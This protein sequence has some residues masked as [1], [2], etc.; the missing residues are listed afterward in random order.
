MRKIS[1][2]HWCQL[3]GRQENP[4]FSGRT[5]L[6]IPDI[7]RHSTPCAALSRKACG[8]CK[9]LISKCL[10]QMHRFC[11]NNKRFCV[12]LF[13]DKHCWM[14]K[15]ARNLEELCDCANFISETNTQGKHVE[16]RQLLGK[17]CEQVIAPEQQA[18]F[19]PLVINLNCSCNISVSKNIRF[20]NGFDCRLPFLRWIIVIRQALIFSLF[21]KT[22]K[23]N[24]PRTVF[25]NLHWNQQALK[26]LEFHTNERLATTPVFVKEF[27]MLLRYF[28]SH[29]I[30]KH[31]LKSH[32]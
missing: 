31:K 1:Q 15:V 3:A 12:P 18:Q 28:H 23:N 9:F 4:L 21:T 6:S 30:S 2:N 20:P 17:M 14:I 7:P 5:N 8:V 22:K 24:N 26:A 32:C 16:A 27:E 11:F 29:T 13:H 25:Y 19:P 10:N